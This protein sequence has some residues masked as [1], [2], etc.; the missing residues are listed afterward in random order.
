MTVGKL[1]PELNK[2]EIVMTRKEV[3]QHVTGIS[4][5]AYTQG[6]RHGG[7]GRAGISP[8]FFLAE[9]IKTSK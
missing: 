5:M 7:G 2:F 6:R 1:T 4:E 3:P 8:V 9:K